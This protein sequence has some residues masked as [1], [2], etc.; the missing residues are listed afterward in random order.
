SSFCPASI[1]PGL[2]P[3]AAPAPH[4]V[5]AR[6]ARI[7]RAQVPLPEVPERGRPRRRGGRAQP[8]RDAATSAGGERRPRAVSARAAARV[9]AAAAL[10]RVHALPH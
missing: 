7:S 2:R 3:Q 10:P 8:Q 5:H 4:R 6:A 9:R 1:K